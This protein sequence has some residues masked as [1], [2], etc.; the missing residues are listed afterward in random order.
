MPFDESKAKP[1]HAPPSESDVAFYAAHTHRGLVEYE[2]FLDFKRNDVINKKVLDLGSGPHGR[3]ARELEVQYGEQVD[4][5]SFDFIH[6]ATRAGSERS[7]KSVA[8]LF[9]QLP[10]K[11][12][13]FDMVTS[14]FGFPFYS[15]TSELSEKI[16]RELIRITKPKGTIILWPVLEAFLSMAKDIVQDKATVSWEDTSDTFGNFPRGRVT[17]TKLPNVS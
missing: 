5:T 10:F 1:R 8:G 14:L 7:Q 13:S 11:D 2:T 4:V 15:K 16:L 17:I 6:S 9:S 3:F 12:N